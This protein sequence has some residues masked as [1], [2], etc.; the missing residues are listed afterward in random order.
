MKKLFAIFTIVLF[1]SCVKDQVLETP[2]STFSKKQ[3]IISYASS[4]GLDELKASENGL[5][6]F[7]F[8]STNEPL[9][10]FNI[11]WGNDEWDYD[12]SLHNFTNY[13]SVFPSTYIYDISGEHAF[14]YSGS[15]TGDVDL[16]GAVSDN[17]IFEYQ[18]LLS[19]V[20]VALIPPPGIEVDITDIIFYGVSY[21]GAYS[22]EQGWM[23]NRG[24]TTYAYP[25]LTPS[26]VN[27]SGNIFY[28][29]EGSSLMLLPQSFTREESP[30]ISFNYTLWQG[31]HGGEDGAL[32]RGHYEGP[33]ADCGVGEWS[34]GTNYLY[35]L[36]FDKQAVKNGD[37]SVNFDIMI[38]P[39][40]SDI[41]IVLE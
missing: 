22:F 15:F 34:K 28:A 18:H 9:S 19:K 5:D 8:N 24:N 10:T 37:P 12:A 31:N 14:S 4:F 36:G 6:I 40:V 13:F 32:Y 25:S 20:D 11:V 3:T 2:V 26:N 41:S 33:L 39:W 38:S 30:R 35:V 16:L 1:S 7:A 17:S 23:V 29:P 27:K 21:S